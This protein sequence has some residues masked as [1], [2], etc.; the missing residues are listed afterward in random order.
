[1][2][3]DKTGTVTEVQVEFRDAQPL[4]TARAEDMPT[5][6]ERAATLAAWSTH[7]LSRALA[8]ARPQADAGPWHD[9]AE[10]PGCGV[11]ARDAQGTLWRLGSARWLGAETDAALC[12]GLAGEP[13]L[14]LH[15]DEALREDAAAAVN[16][17]RDDGIDVTLLSGDTPQRVQRLAAR[18]GI[19]HALAAAT[20]EDKLIAL[21]ERQRN[22]TAV[23]M[24]GDGVNDAP[25]LAQAD[26]SFALAHGAQVARS[27]ADAV[28]LSGRLG[29][30]VGA[31]RLSRRAVR[32]I[33]QNLAWAAL[34]NAAC[35]PLALL[36]HLPPW[37]AGLG[38]A[39]SS[40]FVVLNAMRL[41]K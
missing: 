39:A 13:R 40:A 20:P 38:M 10:V 41:A 23:A 3:L 25:V 30:V 28:L 9:V 5:L 16:A 36:G 33:R 4:G 35:V 2:L 26:V 7:P 37:A 31:F 15:F 6:I 19:E 11:Q 12:F 18:L 1:V 8:A 22:G 21:R 34:Y 14:A 17:L 24:V 29:D 32:V 27:A